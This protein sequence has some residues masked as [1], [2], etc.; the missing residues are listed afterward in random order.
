MKIHRAESLEFCPPD[1]VADLEVFFFTSRGFLDLW[2]TQGGRPVYWLA[3]ESGRVLAALPGVE[4]G[5]GPLRRFESL[6]DGCYGRVATVADSHHRAKELG[7][8]LLA[9]IA[10][11]RYAK[12]YVTDF[13]SELAP[14]PQFEILPGET[15]LVD[16][17]DPEWMPPDK[18]LQSEL[19]RAERENVS[20]RRFSAATDLDGFLSLVAITERRHNR[21]PRYSTDF[22]RALAALADSDNRVLWYYVEHRGEPVTAHINFQ[23]AEMFLNWQVYFDKRH[24][25]LKANQRVIQMLAAEARAR[26]IGYLN[27]GASP[28]DA[29]ALLDYKNK[30]G[31]RAHSYRTFCL[32][33]GLGRIL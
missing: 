28:A 13:R 12:V 32:K 5:W 27:L 22:Y 8:V 4:F 33:T 23:I 26:N 29:E 15:S 7:G 3:E 2:T 9:A 14:L 19:R 21:K 20:V 18:K 17:S 24:S 1:L 31:G 16:I 10:K 25:A 6:P 30:W 11:F